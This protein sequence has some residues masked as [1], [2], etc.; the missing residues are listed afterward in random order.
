M[1]WVWMGLLFGVVFGGQH[2]D[3]SQ[4]DLNQD[5]QVNWSD[6]LF[7]VQA[8]KANDLQGDFNL[9]GNLTQAD[10]LIF[11]Q[12]YRSQVSAEKSTKVAKMGKANLRLRELG[13]NSSTVHAGIGETF[14]VE[15]FIEGEGE[16]ITGVNVFLEFD[17]QYLL[18][19]PNKSQ[20][21][22]VLDVQPFRQGLFLDGKVMQNK[23]ETIGGG[24]ATF[25]LALLSYQEHTLIDT[26]AGTPKFTLGNGV[27]ATFKLR[28][29]RNYPD[30]TTA[31]RVIQ[32]LP[33]LDGETGYFKLGDPDVVYSFDLI[34]DLLIQVDGFNTSYFSATVV[35][36]GARISGLDMEIARFIAGQKLFYH[37][38][39]TT[40]SFGRISGGIFEN[41]LYTMRA[42]DPVTDEIVG[43]W[44][45]IPINKYAFIDLTLPIGEPAVVNDP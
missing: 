4:A 16:Q 24:V 43:E 13:S 35:Q 10:F 25:P 5:G 19:L 21:T 34:Q 29:I 8:F 38:A 36:N 15:L 20:T 14:T 41:G 9:D 37:P 18:L 2:I 26:E 32:R 3:A 23:A 1:K 6:Y 12:Y 31:V 30:V 39:I 11:A 33:N 45:S 28:V 27:L 17:D 40:D 22:P 44:H 7:F 42:R